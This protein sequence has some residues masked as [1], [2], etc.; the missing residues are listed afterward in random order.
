MIK[1]VLARK[2]RTLP[3]S[4]HFREANPE[5][6]FP[7]TPCY[8]NAQLRY[9]ASAGPRRAGVMS[10]GMGGTNAHV[11]LEEAPELD[12]TSDARG[13]HVVLSPDLIALDG[14]S[15]ICAIPGLTTVNLRDV[16]H[17]QVAAG[18]PIDRSPFRPQE[19]SR[20]T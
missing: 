18:I 6:D 1:T 13:P 12:A 20:A 11:V 19:R 10:T 17:L 3:P 7:A 14:V 4:L 15:A 16:V 5:I 2:H 9:W 8:V